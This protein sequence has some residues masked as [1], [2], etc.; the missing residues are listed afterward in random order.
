MFDDNFSALS[1]R[2]LTLRG[3][4]FTFH[5][6]FINFNFSTFLK[7]KTTDRLKEC[8]LTQRLLN[9]QQQCMSRN[10]FSFVS[11]IFFFSFFSSQSNN[12]SWI[13]RKTLFVCLTLSTRNR[14]TV[15]FFFG[16][17]H[18]NNTTFQPLF[19]VQLKFASTNLLV[20]E[21]SRDPSSGV[22]FV[23]KRQFLGCSWR[24]C[25]QPREKSHPI[26]F[27]PTVSKSK[28][29]RKKNR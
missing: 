3:E 12:K 21:S 15:F 29:H 24:K 17:T 4:D 26:K 8:F 19:S 5:I 16:G 9:S 2:R 18:K 27:Y 25:V 22:G 11:E 28:P 14:I 23:G 10:F 7:T 20:L 1:C 6:L 13:N